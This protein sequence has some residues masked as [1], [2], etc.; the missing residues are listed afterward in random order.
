MHCLTTLN[1]FLNTNDNVVVI[2][3]WVYPDPYQFDIGKFYIFNFS[4][5]NWGV[6]FC[7]HLESYLKD[8]INNY[9]I[10]VNDIK[11]HQINKNV[12]Y[13]PYWYVWSI[14][15]F[16]NAKITD[17]RANLISCANYAARTHRIYN[18]LQLKKKSY[19]ESIYFTMAELNVYTNRDDEY[20]LT[21]AESYEWENNKFYK[22]ETNKN[23]HD[24]TINAPMFTDSYLNI[25]AESSANSHCRFLTEKTWKPIVCEQL[26]LMLG[27]PGL[28]Q[29]L[30][31]HGVDVYD[32]LIDHKYYDSELDFVTRV[33]K[34]HDVLDDLVKNDIKSLF[35]LTKD[36]RQKNRE[37]FYSMQFGATYIKDIKD[38]VSS[39]GISSLV[40][41]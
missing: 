40:T 14:H 19:F 10:L 16:E 8:K 38:Y 29:M 41:K 28:V 9:I 32:D 37:N 27:N 21:P 20:I 7:I 25:I 11:Y 22:K 2:N 15:N 12:F 30:K 3:D 5:E 33:K 18:Y 24:A 39:C 35:N 31:D 36:R 17:Y 6:D 1:E 23:R 34:M 4:S 26:F 13:F